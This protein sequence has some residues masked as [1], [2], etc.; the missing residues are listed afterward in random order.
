[1]SNYSSSQMETILNGLG[2]NIVIFLGI[3]AALWLLSPIAIVPP[4]HRGVM[5]TLGKVSSEVYSDGPHFRWP[6]LQTMHS[7]NVQIQKGD[8]AGDAASRDMQQVHTTVALN[9][10]IDPA[11]AVSVFRD[12]GLDI[13]PKLIV[14]STQEAVK[15]ATAEYTAEDL[16]VKREEV[17]N[18]IRE[19]LTARLTRHGILV[20]ELSI[21]NFQFSKS[22]NDAIEGKTTAEQLK[23]KADRDLTRIRVEAEQKIASARAEAEALRMQKQEITADLIK[24][25]EV[26]NQTKAIA[27]W[28]GKLPQYAGGAVPFINVK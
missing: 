13:N 9:Y 21:V 18:K 7:V 14:P 23:L 8:G 2:K 24:L 16:I 26:E 6:I 19:L 11:A 3:V 17:R 4:G 1:M 5:T 20:D 12:V 27:K 28:D 10:H 15:A 25:R 22:F